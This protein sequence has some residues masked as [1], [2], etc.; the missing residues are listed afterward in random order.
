MRLQA[1]NA[2]LATNLGT[3]G[4]IGPSFPL[5]VSR[6][7]SELGRNEVAIDSDQDA[8]GVSGIVDTPNGPVRV[9]VVVDET[10]SEPTRIT[11]EGGGIAVRVSSAL[12]GVGDEDGPIR[13]AIAAIKRG[14]A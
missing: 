1:E 8:G 5:S 6:L 13:D 3:L 7:R 11:R 12:H 10:Q 4:T 14:S 2:R 9:W